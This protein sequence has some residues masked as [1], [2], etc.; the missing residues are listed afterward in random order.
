ML[1]LG[2]VIGVG[3][4]V[5]WVLKDCFYRVEEGQLA[6]VSRFGGALRGADGKLQ[7]FG[8]GL[9]GKW[10]F[11]RVHLV[12]LREQLVTLSGEKGGEPVMLNDGN[13]IR[14]D[15]ML[16]YGVEREGLEHFLFGMH[17]PQEHLT[18]LFTCLMRNEVANVKAPPVQGAALTN[19]DDAGGAYALVRRER[20]LLN[21][22]I[23]DFARNELGDQY[24]VRFNAVDITDLHPPDELADAL[25]AVMSA[26]AGADELRF[27]AGSECAQRIL[28]AEKGVEIARLKAEAV[29]A[30]MKALGAHLGTLVKQGVLEEY[31]ARRKAEVL[32]DVRTVYLRDGDALDGGAR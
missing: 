27:R 22:R 2:L 19:V 28:S 5:V 4:Y 8:P 14:L 13:V 26:R 17:H 30:E 23:A 7:V 1:A 16:R 9:H 18:G 12:S 32:S 6:V 21:Q 10:P 11:D 15:S 29:E 25:N 20:Q 31:V 3:L 24:G